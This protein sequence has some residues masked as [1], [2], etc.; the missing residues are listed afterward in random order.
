MR[1]L[2]AVILMLSSVGA[3]SQDICYSG[4]TRMMVNSTAIV[5]SLGVAIAVPV[6]LTGKLKLVDNVSFVLQVDGVSKICLSGG[7]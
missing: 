7:C 5:C 4:Q 6:P 2:V 3:S 1:R